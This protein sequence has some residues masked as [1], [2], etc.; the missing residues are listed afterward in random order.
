MSIGKSDPPP[1]PDYTGA[2][3]A[4]ASGN[5]DAARIA[6]KA[7]RVNQYSP[8][9]AITYTPGVNGDQDQWRMDTSLSP[10]GQQL[11]DI[12]QGINVGLGN[13]AN[14][15][16]GFVQGTLDKPFNWSQVPNAPGAISPTLNKGDYGLT[17][18]LNAHDS[19]QATNLILQRLQPTLDTQRSQLE[20]QLAN[21][22][23]GRGSDAYGTA[24]RDQNMREN[25]LLTN[26][27][28][29]G[30][31]VANQAFGQQAQA[32]QLGSNVAN[33]A[34]GQQQNAA[35]VNQ[36][37]RQQSIQDQE[38]GRTEPLNILNA[39]RSSA[40][41]NLPQFQNVPQQQTVQG[42]NLLGAA[43]AQGQYDTSVYNAQQAQ[44]AGL[45]NAGAT[46]GGAALLGGFN[47][48]SFGGGAA[49]GAGALG[50]GIS[51][52][53]FTLSQFGGMYGWR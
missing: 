46:L 52:N 16:L 38:F 22:G 9:G 5:A 6:A 20:T 3:V 14:K 53:P 18:T 12:N 48:F 1:A 19:Q 25:D 35:S 15:G 41:V 30:L 13:L 37:L 8:Y 43:Q 45:M 27:S 47:P 51:A 50:G 11:F 24:M 49:A 7:N 10:Q 39:V 23:I 33:T 36:A 34:F 31:N 29:Q 40:P 21:Q 26:A 28:L 2:A 4:T 42:P 44:Q 32:A 17:P